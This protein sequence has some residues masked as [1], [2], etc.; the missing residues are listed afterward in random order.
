MQL[1]YNTQ[2]KTAKF[3]P[4]AYIDFIVMIT[5]S[6]GLIINNSLKCYSWQSNLRVIFQYFVYFSAILVLY[7]TSMLQM[8]N[9][10]AT[11]IYHAFNMFCYFSPLFGAIIADSLLGKYK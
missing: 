7:L 9:E 1:A 10:R 8:D 4:N 5:Q 2:R 6:N 11:A 3:L